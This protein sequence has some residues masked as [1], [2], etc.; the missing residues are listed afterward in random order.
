MST[1]S[2]VAI[3]LGL[4]FIAIAGLDLDL[5]LNIRGARQLTAWLG[6]T[7]ARVV[8]IVIGIGLVIAGAWTGLT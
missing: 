5:I 2:A 3:L 4:L 7:R 6:R 8:L 1:E